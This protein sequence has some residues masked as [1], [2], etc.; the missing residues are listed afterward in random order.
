MEND[1]QSEILDILTQ[2]EKPP[3]HEWLSEWYA[4]N[5]FFRTVTTLI[6]YCGGAIDVAISTQAANIMQKRIQNQLVAIKDAL[7]NVNESKIDKTYL[8]SEEFYDLV[9][10]IFVASIKTRDNERLIWYANILKKSILTDGKIGHSP[11]EYLD[12]IADLTPKEVLLAASIYKQQ[13]DYPPEEGIEE[14][15]WVIKHGWDNDK[16]GNL[17][18][19]S[20]EELSLILLRLEYKGLIRNLSRN[21]IYEE[22]I[23]KYIITSLFKRIM[24]FL[25]VEF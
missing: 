21:Q 16:L 6:P 9:N 3:T 25:E 4:S 17:L 18:K 13:S 20:T 10:K 2:K 12:I 8:E 1:R 24:D 11:E 23:D 15:E 5:I 22:A 19:L 7:Y 14:L